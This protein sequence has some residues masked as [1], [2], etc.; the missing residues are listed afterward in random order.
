MLRVAAATEQT[1]MIIW[2]HHCHQITSVNFA[3]GALISR[4]I[5]AGHCV[6]AAAWA[7]KI[8]SQIFETSL[9]SPQVPKYLL[10]P[11]SLPLHSG[12]V[13]SL[14]KKAWAVQRLPLSQG[15]GCL[16]GQS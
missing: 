5:V 15:K 2:K 6:V 10:T 7:Y 4:V 3:W 13:G 11:L 8:I 9:G 1:I 12:L 14:V 16:E